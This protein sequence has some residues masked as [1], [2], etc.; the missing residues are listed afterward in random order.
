MAVP[1]PTPDPAKIALRDTL[2]ARRTSYVAAL[3]EDGVR[4]ASEAAARHL[5]DHIPAGATISLYIAM[6]D[7]LDPE[8]L[9]TALHEQGHAV[10]MP[11]L[12]DG[13][14]MRFL[15]WQPGDAL[16]RGPMRLHQPLG[17]QPE[18][19][20]DLIVAPLL[21]FD[22]TGNRVGYGAG[23][24]DRAFQQFAGARRVGFAW[25][26]QE[27]ARIPHDPWDVPLHAVATEQGFIPL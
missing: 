8:P 1:P 14:T 10:A 13:T 16:E 25:A 26:M 3:G 24:Y 22:R 12:F 6:Q 4:T 2:R 7:E 18:R 15:A 23:H 27:V 11:A 19:A 9:A 17:T 20:P 21:G 5:L